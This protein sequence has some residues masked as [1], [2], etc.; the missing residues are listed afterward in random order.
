MTRDHEEATSEARI[1]SYKDWYAATKA[2]NKAAIPPLIISSCLIGVFVM[3]SF[4]GKALYYIGM[5]YRRA[6]KMARRFVCL[7]HVGS[8]PFEHR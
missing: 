6:D 8:A 5:N 2:L 1:R 4:T 3:L 7:M